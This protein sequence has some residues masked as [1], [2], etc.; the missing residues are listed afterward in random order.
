[1]I[2]FDFF[3]DSQLNVEVLKKIFIGWAVTIPLAMLVSVI[4]FVI[5]VPAFGNNENGNG[6]GGANITNTTVV[7]V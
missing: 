2:F 1:M 3:F 6:G 5:F 7:C 4:M